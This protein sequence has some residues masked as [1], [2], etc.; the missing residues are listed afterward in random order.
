MPREIKVFINPS[1]SPCNELK[2]WLNKKIS[3]LSKETLLMNKKQLMNLP[4]L[5]AN[6]PQLL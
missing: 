4:V 1:C 3:L 5:T 2:K 6:I